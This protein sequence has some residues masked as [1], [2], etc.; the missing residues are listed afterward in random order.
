MK[1]YF[2][3]L[4]VP[5]VT[6][7]LL[8]PA[9]VMAQSPDGTSAVKSSIR[10]AILN[11]NAIRQES[12]V[13]KDIKAQLAQYRTGFQAEIGK[14][15]E[16]LRKANLV[17]AKK[18]TIL[19]PEAFSQERQKFE[20][21]VIAVQ[22]LVQQ[23]KQELRKVQEEAMIKVEIKINEIITAMATKQDID[24][25]LK[26]SQTIMVD[27][28]LEITKEVLEQLDKV[29]PKLQITKPGN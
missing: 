27:R 2:R 21:R 15:E 12:L 29:M 24:L 18:R 4:L 9:L 10:V 19:T 1:P 25:I 16:E 13:I 17:M 26:R 22:N 7:F 5:V 23:R 6:T 8:W 20:Q 14:E 11:L 3:I 28:S